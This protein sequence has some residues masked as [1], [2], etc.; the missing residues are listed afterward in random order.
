M[1]NVFCLIFLYVCEVLLLEPFAVTQRLGRLMEAPSASLAG[2]LA[3][4]QTLTSIGNSV[5]NCIVC[6]YENLI[7]IE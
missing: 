7:I 6:T 4:I 5:R 3:H 2:S 1:K